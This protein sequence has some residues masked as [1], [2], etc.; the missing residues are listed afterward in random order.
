MKTI[1]NVQLDDETKCLCEAQ[2]TP[3]MASSKYGQDQKTNILKA[4]ERS[5][6]KGMLMCNIKSLIVIISINFLSTYSRFLSV[7]LSTKQKFGCIIEN[8][9]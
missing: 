4:V 6:H 1:T 5:C 8:T 3:I 2:M 7:H 9:Y